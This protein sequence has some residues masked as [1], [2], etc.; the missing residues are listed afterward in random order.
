MPTRLPGPSAR[1]DGYAANSSCSLVPSRRACSSS[2]TGIRVLTMQA[3]PP[4][5]SGRESIPGNALTQL[6]DYPFQNL[7]VLAR[8]K[9]GQQ[10]FEIAQI[11][12]VS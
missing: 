1:S 3:S 7:C 5:T 2:H 11:R 8:R 4:H 9:R 10:L 6:L 12:H